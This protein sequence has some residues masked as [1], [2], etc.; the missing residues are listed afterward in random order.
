MYK[1][2]VMNSINKYGNNRWKAFSEKIKRDVYL[3]SSLEYDYWVLIETNYLVENFCEQPLK[4]DGIYNGKQHSSIFDMW[5]QYKDESEKFVEIK[6][7]S[8]LLPS[9]PRFEKV[10]KQ[11]NIQRE[12]CD[13]NGVEHRVL[14]EL[15]I[16]SNVILL[17]NQKV[18]LPHL[19]DSHLIP[20]ND[21]LSVINSIYN[22]AYTFQEI[23]ISNPNIMKNIILKIIYILIYKKIL[24][25]NI[26]IVR[27][28]NE[29]EV[30]LNEKQ[31]PFG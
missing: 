1:P 11:I 28:G 31:N 29:T 16:R 3:S 19:K 23:F 13:V 12:W 8:D 17:E 4:V 21:I 22:G 2:I 9:S 20:S 30:K 27:L 14:T 7:S 24:F 6:Y 26:D 10:Q 18:I 5:I 15:D 25:S